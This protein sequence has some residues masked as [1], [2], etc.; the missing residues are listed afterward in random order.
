MSHYFDTPA[1]P[2]VRR[3]IT[4]TI[5]GK[6]VALTTAT[7]VF[8]AGRL[9]PGTAVL[10]A[11]LPPP[12]AASG[13]LL[14]L[15]CGYGPIAIGLA[16]SCPGASVTAVDTNDRA[17]ELTRLNAQSAGV[18]VEALSPQ[19]VPQ[20]RA[21]DQI[22]SNPPIHVG[23]AALHEML[24]TWLGRLVPG[25]R[26]YFVVQKNLGADSLQA[27]L[28]KQGYRTEK[29]ASAKGYRVLLVIR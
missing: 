16:A 2:D 15:G 13:N 12:E 29:V 27:W 20:D 9:D 28:A 22:W 23:K 17:L 25:G 10:L 7:G 21:F 26:A 5:W 11:K 3:Q 4:T 18:S 19:D 8:S 6:K 24:D 1:G 14:D